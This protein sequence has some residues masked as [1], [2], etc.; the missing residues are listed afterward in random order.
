MTD[1]TERLKTLAAAVLEADTGHLE[2]HK[3][4]KQLAQ[5]LAPTEPELAQGLEIMCAAMSERCQ[6]L[7]RVVVETMRAAGAEELTAE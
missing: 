3:L 1:N 7:L 4:L 5:I 2:H 6:K